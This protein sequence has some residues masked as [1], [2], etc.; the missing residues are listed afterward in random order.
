MAE[1][2]IPPLSD[3]LRKEIK[4]AIRI[5]LDYGFPLWKSFEIMVRLKRLSLLHSKVCWLDELNEIDRDLIVS[6]IADQLRNKN[7][8]AVVNVFNKRGL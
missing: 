7:N 1:Y 6:R 8:C 4:L 3:E 2:V 5:H